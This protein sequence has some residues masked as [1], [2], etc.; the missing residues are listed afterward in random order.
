MFTAALMGVII[1]IVGLAIDAS[2]AYTIKAK[3]SAAVD[4]GALAGARSLNVGMD[5]ASQTSSAQSTAVNFVNANFPAGYFSST[6]RTVTVTVAES[7]YRTRTV[8]VLAS[9]SAPTYFLRIL[10]IG[11]TTIRAQGVASRRDVNMVLVLDRSSSM[12]GVMASMLSAARAFVQM[13]AEGRDNVGLMVFG[14]S[15][16]VAFPNPS[17]S[18]PASNFKSA[19]P[20]VDTLVSQTVNGGNTGTA[21]VLWLAYQELVKRNEPGALNL[22]VFFTDGLPNGLVAEFND[23]NSSKN[24]L[25]TSSTCTYKKVANRPMIGFVSQKSGF[26]KTGTTSGVKKLDGSTVSHVDEGPITTNSNGCAY[27]SNEDNVR[28]D[29]AKMPTAD[30]YGNLTTGYTTVD[31]SKIDSPAEIGHASLNAADNAV[32]RIR[33]DTTLGVVIYTIGYNGGSEKPDETWMKRISNDPSSSGY[34]S[35]VPAGLYVAAPTTA[36]LSG[37]FA[38]IASEI[39][40][41]AL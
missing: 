17:P 14:G 38:K 41:L 4:S 28:Q 9:V 26:A 19:S 25:K 21:Q 13:F 18:G 3:L 33:Q 27:K 7:S 6:N 15:S 32:Q 35:S 30:Y 22:I 20:N 40:R 12:G 24:L 8:A 36:E 23:S 31:L 39:L 1:P 37:A 10:G 34:D 16:V 29:V 2:V 5:L 11:S